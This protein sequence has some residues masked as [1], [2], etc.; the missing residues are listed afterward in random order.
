MMA[1]TLFQAFAILR[2][3]LRRLGKAAFQES[4]KQIYRSLFCGQPIGL[5][6]G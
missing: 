3:K 5:F 1:F 6:S 4:R 2:G